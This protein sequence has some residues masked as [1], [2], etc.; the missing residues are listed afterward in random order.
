[1]LEFTLERAVVSE[2]IPMN[3]RSCFFA[4]LL[5]VTAS[6]ILAQESSFVFESA[7]VLPE[8]MIEGKNS[9]IHTQ[10]LVVT[11]DYYLVTGR[12]ETTPKRAL[13]LRFSRQDPG[14]VEFVDITPTRESR[15]D[16]LGSANLDH[17]GGFD[18]DS[19]GNLYVPISTSHPRG[20]SLVYRFRIAP[21]KPLTA[22]QSELAFRI[23]D[24]IGAICCDHAN[25]TLI[26]ANWD[27]KQVY[28]WTQEGRLIS[29]LERSKLFPGAPEWQLAVQ[30]WKGVRKSDGIVVAGGI[31]KSKEHTTDTSNAVVQFL[32]VRGRQVMASYRLPAL[33]N[34]SR[35]VTNEGLCWF[36]EKLYL[37][38]EDIG[39]GAKVLRYHRAE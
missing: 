5:T 34:V 22:L 19:K 39:R 2:L 29:K 35:P 31:D 36:K 8:V 23:D 32:D 11:R 10:G 24:H 25:E 7:D 12:L 17:P 4:L 13:L 28:R 38:P 6:Q 16:D 20:P 33:D 21:S 18:V 9:K 27:T 3:P 14:T 15:T 30:D 1:M 37:L 26:G